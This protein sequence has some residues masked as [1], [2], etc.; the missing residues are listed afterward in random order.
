M[1]PLLRTAF[2]SSRLDRPASLPGRQGG[3]G[4]NPATSPG[5][6][7]ARATRALGVGWLIALVL[8]Q[9]ILVEAQGDP[10]ASG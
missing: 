1:A 10:V 6:H 7:R 8:P 4:H 2:P 5:V 3:D 9:A